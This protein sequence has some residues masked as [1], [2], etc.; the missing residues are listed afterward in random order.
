MSS[1]WISGKTQCCRLSLPCQCVEKH[2]RVIL[3]GASFKWT[4]FRFGFVTTRTTMWLR[5]QD[6]RNNS[7]CMAVTRGRPCSMASGQP[8]CCRSRAVR[9]L[10]S[11]SVMYPDKGICGCPST[12]R[13]VQSV[14][15]SG[16]VLGTF[17]S[18]RQRWLWKLH[19]D[20]AAI[21][22]VECG[23]GLA[24]P[25]VRVQGEAG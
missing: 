14:R 24:I 2:I 13:C 10:V 23:G 5:L 1:V 20:E 25:S 21:V 3:I 7:N 4:L 19:E 11:A 6:I 18:K 12:W 17:D 22:V 9:P 16:C 8:S 15:Y